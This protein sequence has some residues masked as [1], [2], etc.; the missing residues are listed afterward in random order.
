[1]PTFAPSKVRISQD[2][3]T[4]EDNGFCPADGHTFS[5]PSIDL[6]PGS[7]SRPVIDGKIDKNGDDI[8]DGII[9]N[10]WTGEPLINGWGG[11]EYNNF[12]ELPMFNGGKNGADGSPLF[13]NGRIGT[14]YI[15]Y[16]CSSKTVCVAAHL[17]SDF[18]KINPQTQLQTKDEESWIRFGSDGAAKLKESNSVEFNYIL[19]PESGATIGY[20]GCWTI[21]YTDAH[22]QS[23]ENNFVE[24]HFSLWEGQTTSTGKPASD[25]KYICLKPQRES[26]VLERSASLRGLRGM[27]MN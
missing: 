2:T 21:D 24:V 8:G 17:D 4:P 20:E 26:V 15:A 10:G 22:M 1:M 18:L 12:L 23:V 16:D 13:H 3:C 14:A 19:H 6:Y 25:G 9:V 11:T 7:L 5:I 27:R